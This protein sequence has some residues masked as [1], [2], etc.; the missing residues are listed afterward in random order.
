ML[1]HRT[2]LIA[3]T[4]IIGGSFLSVLNGRRDLLP[5]APDLLVP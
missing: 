2:G 4:Y 3:Y 1:M 5:L